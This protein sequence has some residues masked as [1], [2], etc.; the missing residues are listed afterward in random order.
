MAR[1]D[2]RISTKG[3]PRLAAGQRF[4]RLV[5]LVFVDR[6]WQN[7]ARWRWQCDCGAV[8]IAS[9]HDVRSGDVKSCGCLRTIVTTARNKASATHKLSGTPEHRAWTGIIARCYNPNSCG[10][11]NYGARGIQ[12]C[13]RWRQFS[14]FYADLGPRP[15][16]QHSLDRYP[17]NDGNYQPDNCRWATKTE[18]ARNRRPRSQPIRWALRSSSA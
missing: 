10:Y 18:Q 4:N 17:D 7:R 12:V 3:M 14:N 13:E 11:V 16:A 15:S 8:H 1:I 6:D 2:R 9:A 5:A